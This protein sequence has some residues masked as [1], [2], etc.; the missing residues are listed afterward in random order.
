LYSINPLISNNFIFVVN[1]KDCENCTIQLLVVV[2]SYF[3]NLS[4]IGKNVTTFV[5]CVVEL[6]IWSWGFTKCKLQA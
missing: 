4:K 1:R 5:L 2:M 3:I 6:L